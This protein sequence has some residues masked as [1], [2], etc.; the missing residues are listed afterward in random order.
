[1]K[2]TYPTLALAMT[3]LIMYLS[4]ISDLTIVKASSRADQ[5]LS[6]LAH[7][8][9]YGIL[10]FMWLKSFNGCLRHRNHAVFNGLILIGLFLF[11]ITDEIHQSFVPGRTASVMDIGLDFLGIV[12][13]LV[14]WRASESLRGKMPTS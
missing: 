4:S 5:I 10:T 13:G 8:P 2:Y 12:L 3:I 14:I 11:S 6:N 7:I 1:M 9:A